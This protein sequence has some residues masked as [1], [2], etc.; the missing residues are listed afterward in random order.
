MNTRP[1]FDTRAEDDSATVALR[2]RV[3]SAP[4]GEL[5]IASRASPLALCQS[6]QIGDLISRCTGR[7][8]RIVEVKTRADAMPEAELSSMGGKGLFVKE[9]ESALLEQRAD[10]AVHSLKDVP[11]DLPDG[12]VLA[13]VPSRRP[14][15]DVIVMQKPLDGISA[16]SLQSL[17]QFADLPAHWRVGTGSL[18]RQ[19]QLRVHCPGWTTVHVRGNIGT[20]VRRL[21][22]EALDAV[23]LARA[24]LERL[25][26]HTDADPSLSALIEQRRVIELSTTLML[27]CPGQGALCLECLD[28]RT[29]LLEL[30]TAVHDE[31]VARCTNAERALAHRFGAGCHAPFAAYAVEQNDRLHLHGLAGSADGQIYRAQASTTLSP[32]AADEVVGQ[33]YD[34][35][36][37]AGAPASLVP[38]PA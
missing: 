17:A 26:T 32:S 13:A 29:D 18:R 16:S 38:T 6:A 5:I 10:L 2:G 15:T 35:M 37:A 8:C 11:S 4:N 31:A 1:E 19:C 30:L 21:D 12:L 36:R 20:R 23:V 22:S 3:N 33:V 34:N 7:R 9:L 28:S 24:G 14:A 25:D 27:P